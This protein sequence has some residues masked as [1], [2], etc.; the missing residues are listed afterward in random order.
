MSTIAWDETTDGGYQYVSYDGGI[1]VEVNHYENDWKVRS[2]KKSKTTWKKK[3]SVF[4][5]IDD[6][7]KHG[8]KLVVKYLSQCW[9]TPDCFWRVVQDIWRPGLDVCATVGNARC[10]A[11]ITPKNNGLTCLWDSFDSSP[12][13]CNPPFGEMTDWLEKAY[14]EKLLGNGS[15]VLSHE[16]TSASWFSEYL[17]KSSAVWVLSPRIPFE[18]PPG[19]KPSSNSRGS[20]LFIFDPFDTRPPNTPA[21]IYHFNWRMYLAFMDKAKGETDQC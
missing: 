17:Q 14:Q 7:K 1:Q 11:F 10:L 2:K 19:V 6:A 20:M 12:A 9:S 5:S 8:E 16:A 21:P 4:E 18:P 13:W 3:V 15:L